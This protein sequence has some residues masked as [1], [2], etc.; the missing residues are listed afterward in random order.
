MQ[1]VVAGL[2][3]SYILDLEPTCTVYNMC[4]VIGDMEGIDRSMQSLR[5][6]GR[7]LPHNNASLESFGIRTLSI[8]SINLQ[9]EGGICAAAYQKSNEPSIGEKVSN[10]IT[11][12]PR[13]LSE[14]RR[15]RRDKKEEEEETPRSQA[16][17]AR[18]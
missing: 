15:R 6:N 2:S 10:I 3:Q 7:V 5:F 14:Y 8:V 13:K 16:K 17:S 12:A 4:G 1:L 18:K 11:A 9:L